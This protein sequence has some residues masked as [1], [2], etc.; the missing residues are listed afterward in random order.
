MSAKTVGKTRI[1]VDNPEHLA[2]LAGPHHRNLATIEGYFDVSIAAPGGEVVLTGGAGP[3]KQARLVVDQL[4]VDIRAG[5]VGPNE[6]QVAAA[7]RV[8]EDG[9]EASNPTAGLLRVGSRS[10]KARTK[11][12]AAYIQALADA[13]TPLV[14]GVGP[15]GTGKTYLAVLYGATLLGMKPPKKLVVTRPAVEAGEKLGYLPGDLSEK[16]DPYMQPIWDA[17]H[18]CLGKAMVDRRI[19]N[20]SIEVAPLAFMRGRTLKDAFV[21]VDEAQNT[22]VNQMQ[23]V[24]TRLGENS[25]M[26][27]TGDPSQVDLGPRTP[28][29]LAHALDVLKGVKGVASVRFSEVDVQR[30][31]LVGRIVAA[32]AR[33]EARLAA[34]RAEAAS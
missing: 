16:V 17:L 7:C 33:E 12:Q 32:Y 25:Q 8:V 26:V 14:F 28:S 30:H 34:S 24:L 31:P 5:V 6:D 10:F 21:I 15:A 11:A 20:G 4:L 9:G 2:A 19:E 13:D 3:R 23:M 1:A 18:E 27:V 29:G 22:T